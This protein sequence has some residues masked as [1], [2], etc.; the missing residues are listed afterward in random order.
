MRFFFFVFVCLAQRPLSFFA[1]FF[2]LGSLFGIN[3]RGQAF[4]F[5][6]RWW[7]Y[8]FSMVFCLGFRF[9]VWRLA[10]ETVQKILFMSDL[11][12][13]VRFLFLRFPVGF[14]LFS[15]GSEFCQGIFSLFRA[16]VFFFSFSS[17]SSSLLLLFLGLARVSLRLFCSLPWQ[18]SA[19]ARQERHS[20][21][22]FCFLLAFLSSRA[23]PPLP[24]SSVS[25]SLSLSALGS[26]HVNRSKPHDPS[27]HYTFIPIMFPQGRAVVVVVAAF[28]HPSSRQTAGLCK[29]C[30][31]Q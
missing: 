26:V 25:L 2:P 22:H 29:C 30:P 16:F 11:L 7:S 1:V 14:V 28:C 21:M 31:M 10:P 9:M 18:A 23:G 13:W 12:F 6:G 5:C 3:F 19:V 27:L 20:I 4:V 15:C 8:V 24:P 17:F